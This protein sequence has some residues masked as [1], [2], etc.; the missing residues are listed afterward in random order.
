[1]NP[2]PKFLVVAVLSASLIAATPSNANG[3]NAHRRT[4]TRPGTHEGTLSELAAN[5]AS[6][7]GSL[8]A[9]R[10]RDVR[11]E[12]PLLSMRTRRGAWPG[13]GAAS[14][15]SLSSRSWTRPLIV[16]PTVPPASGFQLGKAA[17]RDTEAAQ[18]AQPPIPSAP[19]SVLGT[20]AASGERRGSADPTSPAKDFARSLVAPG[21]F[22]CLD[23][24]WTKESG[25]RATADN[26]T[27]TAYGIAQ[28]L[29][30]TSS[31][32]RSQILRGLAYISARYGTP[33]A[34][35]VFWQRMRWY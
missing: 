21:E 3:L 22:V 8:L 10:G 20:T 1:M 16:A 33:C 25:W 7:S 31:D 11:P 6:E 13:G 34:A 23:A 24:L 27:S 29:T 14:S 2:G 30:E 18:S 15:L 12:T 26:P 35:W 4:E 17:P 32:P 9:L 5:P 28:L 19:S